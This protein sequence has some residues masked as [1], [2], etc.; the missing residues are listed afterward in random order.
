[1]VETMVIEIQCFKV[2]CVKNKSGFKLYIYTLNGVELEVVSEQKDLGILIS[3]DLL[4][5]KHIL[6]NTKKANQRVGLIRRCFTNITRR[7][8]STL[9]KSTVRPLY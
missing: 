1:M 7:K 6:E 9:F 5:R 2:C 3:N 4:P 8:I